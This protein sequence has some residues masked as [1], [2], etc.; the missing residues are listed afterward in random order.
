MSVL[1]PLLVYYFSSKTG[2]NYISA[3]TLFNIFT[4][5]DALPKTLLQNMKPSS[6]TP[7][8]TSAPKV[9]VLCYGLETPEPDLET[10]I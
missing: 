1:K 4:S 7:P 10:L 8:D 2:I 3:E 9:L 6:K 5:S